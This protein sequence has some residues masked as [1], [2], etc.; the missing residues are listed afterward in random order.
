MATIVFN[1]IVSLI[2]GVC[3]LVMLGKGNFIGAVLLGCI[4]V[5]W[6]LFLTRQGNSP[7]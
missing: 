1:L 7:K 6:T 3:G 2:L 5:H 4:V